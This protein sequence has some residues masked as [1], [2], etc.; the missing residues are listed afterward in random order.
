MPLG[1]L[2]G[3]DGSPAAMAAIDAGGRLLPGAHAWVANLWTPPFASEAVRRRLRASARSAGEL[4]ERTERE[5]EREADRLAAAGTT[6]ARAAGLDAEPV[7]KKSWGGEGLVLAQLAEQ[8]SADVVLVGSRG[9]GR[10]QTLL[11]SVSNTT[12]HYASRPTVMVPSSMLADEYDA[13][14]DGPV[15]VGWD[16]SAGAQ[17]ALAAA[18][19][20]FAGRDIV[21]VAVGDD[22]G[23]AEPPAGDRLVAV[24]IAARDSSAKAT[25]EALTTVGEQRSAAAVVVGSRGRS[26]VRQ[27]LLGSVATATLHS[28]YRPVMVVPGP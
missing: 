17:A 12:V 24:R 8:L 28:S 21:V 15:V 13:L 26:A 23:G 2:I 7:V 22:P 1:V 27:I 18:Q 14:A 6:L 11:G 16:G 19:H 10:A 5:G 20:V 3:Y 4:V 9:L 25:S